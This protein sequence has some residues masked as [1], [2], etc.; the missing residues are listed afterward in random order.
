MITQAKM[1]T[2]SEAIGAMFHSLQVFLSGVVLGHR[3]IIPGLGTRWA[4]PFVHFL[5]SRSS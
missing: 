3:G 2:N 1:P 4:I 5:S